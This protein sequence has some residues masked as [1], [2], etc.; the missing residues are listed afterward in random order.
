MQVTDANLRFLFTTWNF[1][2]QKAYE[3]AP[4]WWQEVATEVPS[5]SEFNTYGWFAKMPTLRKWVGDRVATN[6]A[7]YSQIVTNDP[8]ELTIE[9]DRP[10][11]ED[12]QYSIYTQQFQMLGLQAKRQPDVLMASVLQNGQSTAIWDGV[13]FFSATHPTSKYVGQVT[14]ANQQNYWSSGTALTFDNY[15]TV[16]ATMMAYKG[17][18]GLPLQVTPNLLIVP[19]QLEVT[20]RLICEASYVAP[21]T[22]GAITQVGQNENPL[23]GS[24]KVLVVPQL[25]GDATTWY[26]L[27]TTKPI[28]PFIYQNRKS[29]ELVMR[30]NV[31]SEP[32]FVRNQFQYGVDM[33]GAASTALWFLAAKAVG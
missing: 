19:P 25:A 2:F 7:T 23:K 29:P 13:N 20:A 27:D 31:D 12:D 26:L 28:R 6:L 22:M 3:A 32:V 4:T 10:K 15:Q 30:T 1:Q 5:N 8:Y 21:Q 11:I 16:R 18:D 17:E 14:A 24:A 33:R 9:V